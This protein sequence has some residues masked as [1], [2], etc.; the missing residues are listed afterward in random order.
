MSETA[1]PVPAAPAPRVVRRPRLGFVGVGWIGASR[2]HAL[3][4]TELAEVVAVAEPDPTSR[5]QAVAQVPSARGVTDLAELLAM[6]LDGVVIA[7]PSALHAE[8]AR[9]ALAHG[10]AVFCQKPLGRDLAETRS[11]IEAARSA[12][13]LLGV[14]LSYRHLAA[15]EAVRMLLRDGE[16]GRVYAADLFFHNAYGPDKPWFTQRSESGGGC[17]IDLGTHLLDLVLWLTQGSDAEVLSRVLLHGG[18][19]VVPGTEAVEDFALAQLR[20]DSG[21]DVRMACSWFLP[22]GRD[23]VIELTL[24]GTA[25]AASV[26]NVEGSFYDFRAERWHGTGSEVIAQPPDD[27]GAR[28]LIRWTERLAQAPAF[29]PAAEA[30]ASLAGILDTIYRAAA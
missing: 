24:Y 7:T 28:A 12:D 17:L 3:A 15:V 30:Y 4:A 2:M 14:D 5:A 23:C 11:V 21:V 1:A 26:R 29:D 13:R 16:L 20:L 8:Q 6:D 18:E 25:G 22:A 10:V 27:W 9:Q 19:P